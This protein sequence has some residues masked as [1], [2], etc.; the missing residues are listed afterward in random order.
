MTPPPKRIQGFTLI[1]LL[2]VIAIIGILAG[3]LAVGL[4]R[5]LESAKIA[6]LDNTFLQIRNILTEYYV[7]HGTF[8]PAYGFLSPEARGVDPDVL[9]AAIADDTVPVEIA[10]FLQPWMAFVGQ[11]SNE[12]MYDN[13]SIGY[14]TDRDGDIS[15]LEYAPFGKLEDAAIQRH[16]RSQCGCLQC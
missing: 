4:P 5:A 2:V 16:D 12:E 13:F 7:D 14:D 9:L 11:H 8:P 10:F 15:R 1:E 3:F 6:K